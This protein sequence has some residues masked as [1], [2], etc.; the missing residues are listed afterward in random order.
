[1]R[2]L[3]GLKRAVELILLLSAGYPQLTAVPVVENP[4]A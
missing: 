2:M 3:L 4:S 1:M